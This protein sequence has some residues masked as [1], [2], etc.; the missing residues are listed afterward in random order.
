MSQDKINNNA[1]FIWSIAELLRG[2]FKQSEYGKVILPFVILRRLDCLLERTKAEVVATAADLPEETDEQARAAILTA[3]AG[4]G[5]Q[6]Y[7]ASEFT[8]MKMKG[9]DAGHLRANLVDYLL[10]FS[11]NVRD[12]FVE[13]FKFTEILKD[14]DDKGLLW[15]VFDRFCQIDLHPNKVLN[16]EMG[17]LFEELIRRFSEMSNETAGE[18]FTPREVVRLLVDLLIGCDEEALAGKGI[19]RR[20]YDPACGTGGMLSIAEWA[21]R[22][23]NDGLHVDLFGQ[24]LNG[25]S[26]ATCKSDMLIKGHDA[27]RIAYG[28]TLTDDQHKH[29]TFHYMLSNPPYGVDWKKYADAIRKEA[30]DDGHDGRFGAGLPRISDG[31]LLFVQHMISK[32]RDDERGSRIGIVMNGSP[33]FT[34]GAGSGE[35][36]IRRWMLENDWVEAI[37]A[38]PTDIFYN[39]GIQ[40]YIWILSNRKDAE[41]GGKVQLIDASS[42]RFWQ[43]MRK[44]LGSKRRLIPDEA[45]AEIVR[46]YDEFLNGDAGY[47]DVSKIFPTTAFGYREIRVERPLRLRF[48]VTSDA[49]RKIQA[50]NRFGDLGERKDEFVE[51]LI[52]RLGDRV[53]MDRAEFMPVFNKLVGLFG[54]QIPAPLKKAMIDALSESDPEAEICHDAK[55]R[56]EPDPK[57]RDHELVPLDEDWETYFEREVRP[58]VADAWVDETHTDPADGEVGRVGYEINF[59]RYFYQYVPPRPLAE[60]DAELK[61]LEAEIA[62]LLKEVVA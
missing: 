46:I 13:K 18:H 35:S 31:Q 52:K 58:F 45:R 30:E 14:L 5:G 23:A 53:W 44:S 56:P 33:L 37:I 57:L 50:H 28:N 38:L 47:G 40:T 10:G 34:G 16:I 51:L 60:I 32:M 20:V 48:E 17:Y 43:P 36:E 54:R 61:A 25:E 39:T 1:A 55:G 12:I 11:P 59:N 9:E 22:Q 4:A 15:Q 19:I 24:E 7:N 21:M 2:D 29:E 62:G 3:I 41:R 6:I 26:F 42:E 8:F 49:I 27:S